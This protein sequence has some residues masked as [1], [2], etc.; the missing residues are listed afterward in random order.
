MPPFFMMLSIFMAVYR[1]P[2]YFGAS[3]FGVAGG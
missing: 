2:R 1:D 3:G